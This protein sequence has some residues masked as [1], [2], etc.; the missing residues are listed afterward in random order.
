MQKLTQ[1]GDCPINGVNAV[2]CLGLSDAQQASQQPS[3]RQ[4]AQP[5][6]SS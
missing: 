3:P 4:L 2:S 5:M 1:S 6:R